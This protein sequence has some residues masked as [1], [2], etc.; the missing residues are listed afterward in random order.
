MNRGVGVVWKKQTKSITSN[1]IKNY[2]KDVISWNLVLISSFIILQELFSELR[3]DWKSAVIIEL[4]L[5]VILGIYRIRFSAL[6]LPALTAVAGYYYYRHNSL[7]VEDAFIYP[8]R[9]YLTRYSVYFKQNISFWYGKRELLG[10]VFIASSIIAVVLF[11][12][13][14]KVSTNKGFRFV[15]P[16]AIIIAGGIVGL[17]PR[18][19][20]I[21]VLVLAV[22]YVSSGSDKVGLGVVLAALLIMPLVA[23]TPAKALVAKDPEL[24]QYQKQLYQEANRKLL[25]NFF[26]TTEDTVDNTKP[27]YTDQEVF[28]I[29][30]TSPVNGNLYLTEFQG[31]RYDNGKWTDGE[32]FDKACK[33]AG[34][35]SDK[36]RSILMSRLFD[37]AL[38]TSRFKEFEGYVD[39][40]K[41]SHYEIDYLGL[42]N[43]IAF[44]PYGTDISTAE[45][46]TFSDEV[47]SHKARN[48]KHMEF[49]A[50]NSNAWSED[51]IWY[52]QDLYLWEA[53]EDIA[54]ERLVDFFGEEAKNYII[55]EEVDVDGDNT[56]RVPTDN[57]VDSEDEAY[58]D[59]YNNYVREQYLQVPEDDQY[60]KDFI[61]RKMQ[62]NLEGIESFDDVLYNLSFADEADSVSQRTNYK[63][64]AL[65][66][67]TGLEE[68]C[69]YSWHLNP[70]PS[71]MDSTKFFLT[72]EKKGYCKHFASTLT[73][74]LRELRIPARYVT[75]YVAKGNNMI[76][77]V[78]NKTYSTVIKD[79]NEHAWVE[80][81][82]DNIGWIPFEATPGYDSDGIWLPTNS[83]AE[84]KRLEEDKK[85][86]AAKA[87]E[88]A[89]PASPKPQAAT[90]STEA[91][92][93]KDT[94]KP[95]A[96]NDNKNSNK[97]QAKI[98][99]E[100]EKSMNVWT[101]RLILLVGVILIVL[102]VIYGKIK[103][104]RE[105]IDTHIKRRHYRTVIRHIN[106]RMY[107]RLKLTHMTPISSLTDAQYEKALVHAYP[108]ITRESWSRYMDIV[109]RVAFSYEEV[110]KEDAEYCKYVYTNCRHAKS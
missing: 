46:V 6:F 34:L 13:L 60:L 100:I 106:R 18:W 62:Q 108:E 104:S 69:K 9:V 53:N 102:G 26:A 107:R 92:T 65:Y 19:T 64:Y 83:K 57:P 51:N 81:Y 28:S 84:E 99:A 101:I 14:A 24:R 109:K 63:F 45:G 4:A 48:N 30:S 5:L 80:I 38:C 96:G 32:D 61:V 110:T 75:G 8:V 23:Q 52:T 49:T 78:K 97:N 66:L 35:D 10:F 105:F 71:G 15:M 27:E 103:I 59:W 47:I 94:Q 44:M 54:R 1:Y 72:S 43:K 42:K 16:F 89:T 79:R 88:A 25:R 7:W 36:M 90:K 86:Q 39:Y 68:D 40:T 3:I 76:R 87:Q 56:Y 22:V 93:Q 50:V 85:E 98:D 20:G 21:T 33:A 82:L 55:Y 2:I 11:E 91:D 67:K 58:W 29:S 31:D 41:K 74:L 37:C 95:N 77:D 70:V 73:L 12:M 17:M